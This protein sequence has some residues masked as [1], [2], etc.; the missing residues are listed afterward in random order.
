MV[1]HFDPQNALENRLRTWETQLLTDRIN[2]RLARVLYLVLPQFRSEGFVAPQSL[3]S[4]KRKK[5]DENGLDSR[6][7]YKKFQSLCASLRP[8]KYL[9]KW[10]R[11]LELMIDQDGC[12]RVSKNREDRWSLWFQL[13]S[14]ITFKFITPG[15]FVGMDRWGND[16]PIFKWL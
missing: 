13:K 3:G 1:R 15:A 12:Q 16:S 7:S 8:R 5:Q 10:I 11:W 9:A 6:H 4:F 2:L 14:F